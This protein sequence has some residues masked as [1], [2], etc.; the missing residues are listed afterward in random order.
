MSPLEVFFACAF[1][2]TSAVA[3]IVSWMRYLPAIVSLY[4]IL[5]ARLVTD[6]K[7]TS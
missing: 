3:L 1:V 2:S 7:F 5:V 6:S 4:R